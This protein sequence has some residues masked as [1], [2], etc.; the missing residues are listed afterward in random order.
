MQHA[1]RLYAHRGASAEL[2]ESLAR[3]LDRLPEV[4]PRYRRINV[5]EPY[6]LKISC[7]R[8]KLARTRARLAAGAGAHHDPAT[9]YLGAAGLVELELVDRE[10]EQGRLV[11]LFDVGVK[12]APD[13]A[14]HLV[15]PAGSRDDPRVRALQ[16]WLDDE[17]RRRTAGA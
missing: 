5:E 15:Y 12:V 2:L 10:L 16:D 6:R 14:Y 7:I 1:L 11:R 9:D 8:A 4:D 17:V 3:D 13:Y